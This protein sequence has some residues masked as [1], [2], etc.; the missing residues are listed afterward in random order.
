MRKIR[1]SNFTTSFLLLKFRFRR[2]LGYSKAKHNSFTRPESFLYSI[3]SRNIF[4][5]AESIKNGERSCGIENF[6]KNLRDGKCFSA[7]EVI[8]VENFSKLRDESCFA[9]GKEKVVWV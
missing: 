3:F 5:S 9:A 4:P 2:R 1:S 8:W 7:G 6:A